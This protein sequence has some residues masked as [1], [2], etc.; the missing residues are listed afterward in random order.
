MPKD[1]ISEW[2][3]T[4]DSNTDVGGINIAENCAPSGINNAIREMMSQVKAWQ[5]GTDGDPSVLGQGT[6]VD[7]ASAATTDIGAQNS[8]FLRVTGTTTITSFGT[9]YRGPR[10]MRF[11]G[12][13]TLTNSATLILPGAANF[14]TTAGD[15]LVAVPKATSG[16]ADGWYVVSVPQSL[17]GFITPSSTNTLTNKTINFADN[18]L[19]GV[20]ST[21]TA[22]TLTNKTLTS[23]TLTSPI[24]ND[25]Y[26]EEV[27]TLTGTVL[28]PAN[29]SIQSITLAANTTFTETFTSGQSMT[30][31]IDDGTARTITW[32][33]ISWKTDNG[34]A[35]TLNTTGFTAVV[36][37]KVGSTLFGARV[38][39]A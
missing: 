35:P 14:T 15:V 23:P 37:W 4:P 31:M 9:N 25:G 2:S 18:T 11:A 13:V 34:A 20:A 1:K 21:T 27:F 17:T 24:I 5:A 33:T 16:T 26:T 6:E 32:P 36:L 22:Q 10:Y 39:N 28:S 19:T 8:T 3:L 7:I 30:L 38:G 29:G 12:A